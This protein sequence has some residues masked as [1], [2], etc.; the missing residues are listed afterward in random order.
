MSTF[1]DWKDSVL[2]KALD[3]D[4]NSGPQCVDTIKSWAEYIT[5]KSWTVTV[6]F[7]NAKDVFDN[8]SS[9]YFDKIVNDHSNAS[10]VPVQGDIV[11]FA[12]ST[13]PG[14]TS[15]YPNPYGHTAVVEDASPNRLILVQQDG[16][17]GQGTVQVKERQWRYTRCIGWLHPKSGS[18]PVQTTHPETVKPGTWN[19]RTA[20]SLDGAIRAG[21]VLGG[22]VYDTI[23]VADGWRQINFRNAIGYVGPKAW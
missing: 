16:S 20:P 13:E 14:Y 15:V 2:G 6:G 1:T 18:D 22:Q 23:I 17:T 21:N 5:G 7:G 3:I 12:A 9:V 8:A 11:V 19:V 10:Q 4:N